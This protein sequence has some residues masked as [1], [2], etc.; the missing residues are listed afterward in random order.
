[1]NRRRVTANVL[2]GENPG[3]MVDILAR[4]F[5]V[6]VTGDEIFVVVD[7]GALGLLRVR[8]LPELAMDLLLLLAKGICEQG[9]LGR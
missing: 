9:R 8:A 3:D 7:G 6:A 2:G 5:G 1:M 4:D